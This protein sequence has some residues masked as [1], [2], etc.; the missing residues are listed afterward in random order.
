[1]FYRTTDNP[2]AIE[3]VQKFKETYN[4]EVLFACLFGSHAYGYAS[5]NSDYDIR[6]IYKEKSIGNYFLLGK[7]KDFINYSDGNV[8]V[9]AYDIGKAIRLC[10]K[11]NVSILNW[12]CGLIIEDN[13]YMRSQLLYLCENGDKRKFLK[14]YLG[15]AG[16]DYKKLCKNRTV[17]ELRNLYRDLVD[18]DLAIDGLGEK[19]L[20]HADNYIETNFYVDYPR[21][22][23]CIRDFMCYDFTN[24]YQ[25]VFE[26]IIAKYHGFYLYSKKRAEEILANTDYEYSDNTLQ[27]M[28]LHLYRSLL[29]Y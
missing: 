23:T 11:S 16:E 15:I 13:N 7:Y 2:I 8:D 25:E 17:K 10:A 9:E 12:L 28:S 6:I 14:H 20:F 5:K 18:I 21:P 1:M 27:A 29:G 26:E 4:K 19:D 24:K 3:A 22:H